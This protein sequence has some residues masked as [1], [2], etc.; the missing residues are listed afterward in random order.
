[1]VLVQPIKCFALFFRMTWKHTG[2]RTAFSTLRSTRSQRSGGRWLRRRRPS[3]WRWGSGAQVWPS[4]SPATLPVHSPPHHCLTLSSW[5]DCSPSRL[6]PSWTSSTC[7]RSA[8]LAA[9]SDH[10][11]ER[12]RQA[13]TVV[14]PPHFVAS[15]G[16]PGFKGPAPFPPTPCQLHTSLF[17]LLGARY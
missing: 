4:L 14:L 17:P 12:K 8:L 3:W 13:A 1:M 15:P 16:P 7:Q 11:G 5:P 2:L 10:R 6:C 9:A